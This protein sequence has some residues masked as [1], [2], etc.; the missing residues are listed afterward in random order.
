[1][2]ED[3]SRIW[4]E[5]PKQA[6]ANLSFLAV[7][8]LKSVITGSRSAGLEAVPDVAVALLCENILI[9]STQAKGAQE[10][11]L[12][13]QVQGG[14]FQ[15]WITETVRTALGDHRKLKL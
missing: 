15:D 7:E 6:E 5:D 8:A 4:H 2:T 10:N 12:V 13:Y 1:M 3:V 14:A 11:D 9:L